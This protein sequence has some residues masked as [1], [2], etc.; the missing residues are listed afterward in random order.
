[1]VSNQH[2]NYIVNDGTATAEDV[3][4]LASLIK[5]RVR[6]DLGVQLKEEVQFVGF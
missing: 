4:M 1:M 3:V 2:P 6:D 5:Q